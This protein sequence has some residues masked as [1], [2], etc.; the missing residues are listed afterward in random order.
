[1]KQF[2]L[3]LLSIVVSFVLFNLMYF[4]AAIIISIAATLIPPLEALLTFLL[5]SNT[6]FHIVVG[7]LAFVSSIVPAIVYRAITRNCSYTA[8]RWSFYALCSLVCFVLV[9]VYKTNIID[10]LQSCIGA[11]IALNVFGR[12]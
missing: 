1:M 10:R 7:G 5:R 12:Y 6:L 3:C 2:F 4:L 11:V 9:F 8:R